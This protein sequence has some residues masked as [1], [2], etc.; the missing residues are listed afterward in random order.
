MVTHTANSVPTRSAA[1]F[2]FAIL[3]AASFALSGTLASGLLTA[4]WS[5]TLAVTLRMTV[6]ALAL[7]VPSLLALRGQ[8]TALRRGFPLILAYGATA[9]VLPQ[10]FY[11]FA[12]ERLPVGPA[13]V[14]E[15]MS[16]LV[17]LGWLWLVHRQRPSVVMALGS[18][19][20]IFGLLS[21]IGLTTNDP[22]DPIGVALAFG[23]TLGAASFYLLSGRTGTGL[24]PIVLA[25]GGLFV[26]AI[27]LWALGLTGVLPFGQGEASAVYAGVAIPA[28][29]AVL[30]L[31]LV[32]AALA[33]ATGI[34]ATR[35]LG[36]RV[37]SFFGMIEVI[38]SFGYAW[39][40]LGQ[41]P[42]PAQ[43]TGAVGIVAGITLVK[44]GEKE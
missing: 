3:S 42:G 34:A 1:G 18:A 4:G 27:L 38:L 24:P 12:L 5:P 41:V 2:G 28:W 33:Y 21:V 7:L 17:V 31:G 29:T 6:G 22:L 14:I 36:S 39:V 37:A 20:A 10:T 26:G 13:M 23:G 8:W 16:P 30:A 9:V 25:G 44:V 43:L 40:L 11:F 19:V 15:Y 32:S 35:R